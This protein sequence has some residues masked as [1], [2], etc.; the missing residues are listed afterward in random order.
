[1]LQLW[2]ETIQAYNIIYTVLLGLSL[3]YWIF[4]II[5]ALDMDMI[6]IDIDLDVDAD[7]DVDV[8]V[9][10][11]VDGDISGMSG[12][13]SFLAFFNFGKIPFMIIFSLTSLSMWVMGVLS[14]FYLF[15]GNIGI[16]LAMF[17]PILFLG[18]TITKFLTT[19]LVPLFE[20]M[21]GGVDG[22]NYAGYTGTVILKTSKGKPG[23]AEINIEGDVHILKIR[24]A[25]SSKEDALNK[26]R[27]I[28]VMEQVAEKNY[29]LVD[30][31]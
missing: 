1:M 8:D 29:Y 27:S 17:I 7:I 22:I 28:V 6:D 21:G 30:V 4:V 5:G 19:P 9:D 2:T 23:Q 18:L 20:K 14:N 24:L 3:L 25:D 12:F 13:S 10:M 16:A 11:D 15:G 31:L 26:G